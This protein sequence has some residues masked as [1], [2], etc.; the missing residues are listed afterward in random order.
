MLNFVNMSF[1][2]TLGLIL[3]ICGAIML[4]TYKRLN[5]LEHSIIEH[6]RVLQGFLTNYQNNKYNQYNPN[7]NELASTEAINAVERKKDLLNEMNGGSKIDISDDNESDDDESSSDDDESGSDDDE[8]G[9]DEEASDNDSD[10]KEV[11][12]GDLNTLLQEIPN[13]SNVSIK[14]IDMDNATLLRDTINLGIKDGEDNLIDTD[15]SDNSSQDNIIEITSSVT[16][17]IKVSDSNPIAMTNLNVNQDLNND[18]EV[19]AE[20][21]ADGDADVDADADADADTDNKKKSFAKM[22]VDVL[23]DIA[24]SKGLINQENGNKYKKNDLVKLLQEN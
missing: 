23:R 4:Y 22:K 24:I 1:I 3:L 17:V 20:A 10:E 14:I 16:N 8:S 6:G 15:D 11:K 18:L 7:S 2:V 12:V 9:N 19:D 5:I 21:E 13:E